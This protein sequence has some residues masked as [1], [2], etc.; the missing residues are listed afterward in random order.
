MST[1][2][3]CEI[4][5]VQLDRRAYLPHRAHQTDAG[6]DVRTPYAFT[7]PAHGSIRV[8]TGVHVETPHGYATSIRSKSG[9]LKRG[10]MAALG[11][12]DE[13]Y[14]GEIEVIMFNLGSKPVHF[15]AGDKI[16]QLVIEKVI[17]PAFVKV[18]EISGGERGEDGFGSTGR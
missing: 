6:A 4:V 16:A 5:R 10:V 18:D 15:M 2:M 3:M 14:S 17:Y 11:L 9:L 1:D 12:V 7:L 13:G 8:R